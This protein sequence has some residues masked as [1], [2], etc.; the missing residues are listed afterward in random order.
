M[1]FRGAASPDALASMHTVLPGRTRRQPL[2]QLLLACSKGGLELDASGKLQT[3]EKERVAC[4]NKE[5]EGLSNNA[6]CSRE[7]WLI[8]RAW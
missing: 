7:R 3:S 8:C 1:S 4:G 6:I 5:R 2:S